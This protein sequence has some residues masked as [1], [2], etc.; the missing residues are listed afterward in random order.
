MGAGYTDSLLPLTVEHDQQFDIRLDELAGD[1]YADAAGWPRCGPSRDPVCYQEVLRLRR[2]RDGSRR[3]SHVR[4][5]K[6][7]K[8]A[9][10][11]FLHE[12]FE[13]ILMQ[14]GVLR[15]SSA[16]PMLPANGEDPRRATADSADR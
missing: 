8:R 11:Q 12:L 2:S 14:F 13:Q 7:G 6:S 10:D 4:E 9:R 1:I 15:M 3:N 5:R 16:A